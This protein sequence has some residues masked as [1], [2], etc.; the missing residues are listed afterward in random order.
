MIQ[1][2]LDRFQLLSG[3]DVKMKKVLKWIGIVLGVIIAAL[4]VVVIALFVAGNNRVNQVHTFPD[5]NISIPTDAASIEHGKHLALIVCAQ[6]HGPDLGGKSLWFKFAPAGTIDTP[7]LTSGEGGIG[8]T[9]TD[10]N[11]VQ[12]IRHAIDPQGRG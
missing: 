2:S 6:C 4:L 5:D 8:G 1:A 12:A 11:Y 9:F 3:E 10:R 7:N